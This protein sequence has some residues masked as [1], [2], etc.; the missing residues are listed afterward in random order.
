MGVI[1]I[2][3]SEWLGLISLLGGY[4]GRRFVTECTT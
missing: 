4:E 1:V 3:V 2:T